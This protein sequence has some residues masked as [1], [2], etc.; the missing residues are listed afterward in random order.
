MSTLFTTGP[1]S[2]VIIS[3]TLYLFPFVIVINVSRKI[4]VIHIRVMPIC[5]F[6]I[7]VC[8]SVLWCLMGLHYHVG[9]TSCISGLDCYPPIPSR[10]WSIFFWCPLVVIYFSP[11]GLITDATARAIFSSWCPWNPGY[12]LITIEWWLLLLQNTICPFLVLWLYC[13]IHFFILFGVDT[14]FDSCVHNIVPG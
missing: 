9:V 4:W 3:I 1:I 14:I 7:D 5:A 13:Y 11:P 8:W 6:R 2:W 10:T 12:P